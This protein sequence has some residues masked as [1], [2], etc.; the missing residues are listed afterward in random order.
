MSQKAESTTNI[1]LPR[2]FPGAS[3]QMFLGEVERAIGEGPRE[4]WLNCSA[5][6]RIT[7]HGVG[8][9]WKAY[10]SCA[11]SGVAL[12]LASPSRGLIQALCA[13]DLNDFFEIPATPEKGRH[14]SGDLT[15]PS[16][17]VYSASFEATEAGI[18]QALGHFGDHVRTLQLDSDTEFELQTLFYEVATNIRQH[19]DVPAGDL[20]Q[21]AFVAQQDLLSLSF[22]DTGIPFDPTQHSAHYDF[23]EAAKSG[24]TRG[25]GIALIERMT[26][27]MTYARPRDAHNMLTL[28]KRRSA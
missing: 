7:S 19:G 1:D 18:N 13:L 17:G 24:Q 15:E 14:R 6:E 5:I 27:S 9:L 21:V 16:T 26:D 20:V 8:V 12:R 23:V 22:T 10:Q 25:F 11:D 28:A 3:D 2:D 4:I